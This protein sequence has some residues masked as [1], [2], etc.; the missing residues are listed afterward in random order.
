MR[1]TTLFGNFA[2]VDVVLT[3]GA[4]EPK[5]AQ[6]FVSSAHV[7]ASGVVAARLGGTVVVHV[8]ALEAVEAGRALA[9]ESV[10]LKQKR[11]KMGS[12][13]Y[14]ALSLGLTIGMLLDLGVA[15]GTSIN[16]GLPLGTSSGLK[17]ILLCPDNLVMQMSYFINTSSSVQARRGRTLIDVH[18]TRRAGPAGLANAPPI[19]QRVHTEPVDARVWLA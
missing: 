14:K 7:H 4:F 2:F 6:A 1:L 9:L 10:F 11:L 17:L 19:E 3:M 18:I 15:L 8:L 5:A 12:R 13:K 16:V